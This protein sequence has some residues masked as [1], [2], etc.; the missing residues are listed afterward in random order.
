MAIQQGNYGRLLEPGLRK[1]FMETYQEKPE[2]FSQ[3]FNVTTS[4][5]AIETDFR[6]GG[7]GL[8]D[9]KESLGAVKYQDPTTTKALQYVHQEFA[10]GF[11]VERKLIDDEQYNTINKMSSALARAARATVETQAAT[12]L[13]TAI[14]GGTGV[15]APTNGFDGLPL[16][17]YNHVRL[18]GGLMSNR[19][20]YKTDGTAGTTSVPVYGGVA[21]GALSD[22]NLKAAL[23]QAH[24]QVD[25][26]GILI[27]CKPTVLVVPPALEYT[28]RTLVG[29]QNLSVLGTGVLS[30]GS[31][32]ATTAK[33]TLPAFKIVVMDYLTSSTNWFIFDP[34][35]IQLN[36][37][38]RK[39]LEFKN[40]EDFD[41][42][43]AKYRAYMR[44]S[45]GYSDYRG[46]VGSLGT[47]AA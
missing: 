11:T 13:N 18:D 37:F 32:D 26:R 38:W 41:T 29:G 12:V 31:S 30:G 42:M 23:I 28:A 40:M 8:F 7:F 36:F 21:D 22:R 16:I 33:N 35:L 6:M 15:N 20:G 34:T 4:D 17:A 45:A 27:Q 39:K 10:S 2:Q 14:Q 9:T 25:D 47:G 5:K 46:I 43:Q 19:L 44:F 24:A 1:I 3:V